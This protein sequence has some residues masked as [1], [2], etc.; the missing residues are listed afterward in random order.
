MANTLQCA[1]NTHELLANTLQHVANT[2]LGMYRPG[3]FQEA[4]TVAASVSNLKPASVWNLKPKPYTS[5]RLPV[6]LVSLLQ[7]LSSKR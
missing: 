4:M 7:T 3:P 6:Q 5:K 2:L 1:A